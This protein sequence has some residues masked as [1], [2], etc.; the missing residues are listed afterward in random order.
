MTNNTILMLSDFIEEK[1]FKLNSHLI[2]VLSTM[3]KD[4]ENETRV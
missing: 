3:D 2:Y 4:V 1:Q